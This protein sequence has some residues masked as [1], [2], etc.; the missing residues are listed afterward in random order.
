MT[1]KEYTKSF[2]HFFG[3]RRKIAK[4]LTNYGLKSGSKVLDILAGHGFFSFEIAYNLR[5]GKIIA[6]GLKNDL[7]SYYKSLKSLSK[8]KQR[9][10]TNIVEY[11]LMD[12]SQLEFADNSFDFVVNFLGLEDVNMTSGIDGLKQAISECSRVLKPSGILQFTLCLE[13]DEPD[14]VLAKEVTKS[15]GHQ[16]IFHSKDFYIKELEKNKIKI[17]DE[18]W[19]Y[20][21]RKMTAKQAEEELS[22]A[23][24][25]TPKFFKEYG[26]E[27]IPFEELW[28]K[29]GEEIKMHGM[30]YYSE[31]LILIG[32]KKQ[33]YNSKD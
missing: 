25:E 32:K 21:K 5:N 28:K 30:A 11:K 22:F 7:D 16:A 15:I 20:T 27:T 24:N 26:I 3:L 14:Q 23:C 12:V 17:V 2:T 9:K 1:N 29:Y 19:F 6:I 10:I 13:G 31:L 33:K 8:R 4:T 18:K